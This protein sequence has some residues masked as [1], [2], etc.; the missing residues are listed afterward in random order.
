ME[1]DEKYL[2]LN[3]DIADSVLSDF[4]KL[5]DEDEDS[6]YDSNGGEGLDDFNGSG[7]KANEDS[8]S[9]DEFDMGPILREDFNGCPHPDRE[10]QDMELDIDEQLGTAEDRFGDNEYEA[11]EAFTYAHPYA[12]TPLECY[13]VAS[14]EI[15]CNKTGPY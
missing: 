8:D 13:K 10:F 12:G 7:E 3:S 9:K 6:D 2:R 1:I 14:D 4:E 15:P 5:A 11:H